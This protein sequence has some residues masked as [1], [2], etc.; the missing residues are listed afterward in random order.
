MLAVAQAQKVTTHSVKFVA[1]SLHCTFERREPASLTGLH[2]ECVGATAS[3]KQD[4]VIAVGSSGQNGQVFV[5]RDAISWTF[6][7]PAVDGALLYK[8]TANGKAETGAL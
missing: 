1:G 2:I 3:V 6:Q 5:D 7:R 4:T 8:I